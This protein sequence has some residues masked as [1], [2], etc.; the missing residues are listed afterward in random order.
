MILPAQFANEVHN[1][2]KI[3]FCPYCSR[4][5]FYQDVEEGETEYFQLDDTGSLSDLDDAFEDEEEGEFDDDSE[6]S[7]RDDGVDLKNLDDF[8]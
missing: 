2:E 8:D 6:M 1:G 7:D 3:V 5:L 4:I